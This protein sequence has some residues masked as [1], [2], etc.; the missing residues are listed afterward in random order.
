MKHL[1]HLIYTLLLAVALVTFPAALNA[2]ELINYS[3]N[4]FKF[5]QKLA[6]NG[7]VHAQY[8]LALMY[9]K[10][11]GVK[12]SVD[13]AL[14]WYDRAAKSGL[15]KADQRSTYL[16]VKELG[17]NKKMHTEWLDN[18]KT[19]ANNHQPEAMLL[20]GQL[21]RQGLG[22]TKNLNKSLDLLTQVNILGD[23][24]VESEIE[25]IHAEIAASNHPKQVTTKNKPVKLVD[26]KSKSAVITEKAVVKRKQK[27]ATVTAKVSGQTIEKQKLAEKRRRYEKA[28]QQLKLEQQMIDQQQAEVTGAAVASMDDE[29]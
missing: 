13:K 28:M 29:F 21:Y 6:E 15:K 7:N 17:F 24:D 4:V 11:E 26:K 5:Q 9:E 3:S 18:V 16:M 22:V 23:A 20:L 25:S 10:G 2:E 19:D 27:P 1:D 12:A 8:K 14:H